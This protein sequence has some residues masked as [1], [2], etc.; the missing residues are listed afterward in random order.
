[1]CVRLILILVTAILLIS[2][3]GCKK[4]ERSSGS[5]SVPP[6]PP[7]DVIARIH[8]LGKKRLAT[9]TNAAYFMGIWNLPESARLEAQTLDK[10]STAP[11]R[12]LL[13][14]PGTN[15]PSPFLRPLLDDLVQ[16]ECYLEMRQATNDPAQ[17]VFAVK[18]GKE[19]ATLWEKNLALVL[20]SLTGLKT[21]AN[22][23]EN[24]GWS[25][26]KHHAPSLIELTHV[27]D[28]TLIG[29]AQETNRLMQNFVARI[30]LG[31][32]SFPAPLTNSW[33][34]ID[35]EPNRATSAI[36]Q[37]WTLSTALSR[38]SL[39]LV[40]DGE[41]VRTRGELDLAKALPIELGSWVIP[42]NLISDPLESF[43]AIRGIKSWLE[44]ASIWNKAQIGPPPDQTW[45]WSVQG[46]PYQTYFAALVP[47]ASN[48]VTRLGDVL[49]S[50]GNPWLATNGMGRLKPLTNSTG[51]GWVEI[52]F[53]TPF[54]RAY[55]TPT[56][57][58]VCGGC[59]P[60]GP[61]N[62]PPPVELLSE[63]TNP[64][65]L[66]Y[67]DWELTGARVGAWFD[68]GQ[69]LRIAFEKPQLPHDS[70]AVKWLSG[71]APK[72]GN[73]TTEVSEDLPVRLS[74]RRKSSIGLS[75]LELHL[76]ADWLESPGFPGS[77]HTFAATNTMR[78]MHSPKADPDRVPH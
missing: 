17:L 57:E 70:A 48:Y 75:A 1:M 71:I 45:I 30:Q 72:L 67:Y 42:T 34:D 31:Q 16:Q 62:H 36:S 69:L 19:R 35:I 40:G 51:I 23:Q 33:L 50:Y 26:K 49:M 54:L 11:W 46:I 5:Q 41:N 10:L 29:L 61:T 65:K 18:A 74:F 8:W 55:T 12:L 38:I 43:T 22:R 21:V 2:G 44:T 68:I 52:P 27:G 60:F 7:G 56:G 6:V 77:L 3:E 20:E 73:C 28:W 59:F 9:E 32:A 24:Q 47:S 66:I 78:R 14:Q 39:T 13:N 64:P 15:V 76:A 37:R 25:L 4:S 63:V 58:Y 53:L